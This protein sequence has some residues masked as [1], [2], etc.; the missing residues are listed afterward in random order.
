MKAADVL[1]E[2]MIRTDAGRLDRAQQA[3]TLMHFSRYTPTQP[4]TLKTALFTSFNF[5]GHYYNV[6]IHQ[7]HDLPGD[8]WLTI[9][10]HEVGY[11]SDTRCDVVKRLV[12]MMAIDA[13]S[14][15]AEVK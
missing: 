6:Y 2:Y 7:H 12:R 3:L 11:P 13:I 1:T 15:Y 8:W 14:Q 10:G 5:S 4:S 9:N